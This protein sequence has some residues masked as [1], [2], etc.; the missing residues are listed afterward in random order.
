MTQVVKAMLLLFLVS[1]SF[2]G[3]V[4]AS[5]NDNADKKKK[6]KNEET[7]VFQVNMDCH[8]CVQK[9]EGNIPFEKGVKDLKVSLEKLECEVTFREDKTSVDKL[10]EA[11]D[12]LGYK[13]EIKTDGESKKKETKEEHHGHTH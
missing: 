9:I 2:V 1:I 3:F 5:N 8:S 6:K 10:I 13:A 7:V 11:F 4:S 12:K